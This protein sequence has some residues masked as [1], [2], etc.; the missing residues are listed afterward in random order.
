M[1]TMPKFYNNSLIMIR[2]LFL[3]I[4]ITSISGCYN[5]NKSE[6]TIPEVLIS[7]DEM[8]VIITEMQ[9]TEAGFSINK[10]RVVGETLKP[11]YYIGLLKQNNVTVSQFK[12][13]L[14]YYYN[15]PK[16]MEDIY[17]RVL[18]NLSKMQSDVIVEKEEFENKRIADSI[19]NIK[20]DTLTSELLNK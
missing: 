12:E 16:K 9:V 8:V 2:L 1:I 4:V 5:V 17:E 13:N 3:F 19:A 15:S 7:E 14:N 11:E 6:I 18:R 10:N 20:N